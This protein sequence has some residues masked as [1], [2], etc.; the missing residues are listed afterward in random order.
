MTEVFLGQIMLTGFQFAP[1]GFALC[2]GQLMA[3]S[4]NQALFSLLG[5]FYGGDGRVTFALP[6]LRGRAQMAF[7][8]SVDPAWQ[9]APYQIG[10]VGGV[11]NVTLLTPQLPAHN[12]QCSGTTA[13]GT[14]RN[15]TNTL[16]GTNS[17]ATYA[18]A[19]GP[20]VP[21][22]GIGMTGGTQP[23]PNMQPFQ[24]ISHSIA[25]S[26]IFPSRN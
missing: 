17:V 13:N 11:E 3:I 10:E 26:G 14:V 12:H 20:Q 6:D 4:Q 18:P 5:T 24:V 21:V 7:G 22:Q 15:P 2:N 25:L 23:H 9:P 1:K 16:Y 19:N 8:S